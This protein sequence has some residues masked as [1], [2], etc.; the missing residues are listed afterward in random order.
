MDK[1]KFKGQASDSV[2]LGIILALSGGFMDAYTYI[3]RGGVFANAQTGNVIL[4]GISLAEGRYSAIL[5]YL[6]PIL[7]FAFG[8]VF[9][10]FIK[11]CFK[12]IT[13]IHWRQITIFTECVILFLVGLFP[14]SANLFAN[15]LVSFACGIQVESFR[16]IHGCQ[17][18][19]TMC[20]GNLRT[21]TQALFDYY[22]NRKPE[23][24]EKVLLY[25]GTIFAFMIGAICG[26]I[27]VHEFGVNAIWTSS[28][29]TFIG[30]ILMFFHRKEYSSKNCELCEH[31]NHHTHTSLSNN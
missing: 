14:L 6:L 2:W 18:A 5:Q 1:L 25:Y 3:L 12:N 17:I 4:L 8:I 27:G 13:A 10:E 15:S 23:E 9:S 24:K 28:V 26:N 19:T 7:A 21:G 29:L 31:E 11:K 30:F 20:I 22:H 16:K